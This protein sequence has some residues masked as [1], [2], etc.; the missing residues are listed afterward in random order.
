MKLP[1]HLFQRLALVHPSGF[2]FLILLVDCSM[3]GPFCFEESLLLS[4]ALCHACECQVEAT[5]AGA[6]VANFLI[7]E[8]CFMSLWSLQD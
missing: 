5:D 6:A 7:S 8:I 2:I 4:A 3:E 1:Q